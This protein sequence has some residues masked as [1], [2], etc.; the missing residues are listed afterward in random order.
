MADGNASSSSETID[1]TAPVVMTTR[2][3]KY[4]ARPP[5]ANAALVREQLLLAHRYRNVLVEIERARRAVT[6]DLVAAAPDVIAA[7][8]VARPLFA[9]MLAA[10]GTI[11]AARSAVR[12]RAIDP[13]LVDAAKAARVAY[14]DALRVLGKARNAA[15]KAA[16][17]D[18]TLDVFHEN[19]K[20]LVKSAREQCGAFW[21][22][23]LLCEDA[24]NRSKSDVPLWDELEPMDPDFRRWSGEG[25]VGVQLQGGLSAEEVFAYDPRLR[26]TPVDPREFDKAGRIAR[27]LEGA[28]TRA[29]RTTLFLRVGSQG[30]GNRIP[31]WA[32]FP[33]V[34]HRPLPPGAVIKRA[35]VSVRKI[36]PHEKWTTEITITMPKP[37]PAKPVSEDGV[38]RVVAVDL[39]WRV[40]GAEVRVGT[41]CD[42]EGRT[43]IRFDARLMSRLRK[44]E[45]LASIRE[46]NFNLAQ[47]ALVRWLAEAPIALPTWLTDATRSLSQWHASSRLASLAVAWRTQRFDGDS[48]GFEALE[49]WR[50]QDKHLWTWEAAQR[51]NTLLARRE[52]F[53]VA[54]AKLAEDHD[55]LVLEDLNLS[56]LARRAHVEQVEGDNGNARS[57]RQ[58]VSPSELRMALE[59]AFVS[60]GKQIHYASCAYTTRTCNGC[61]SVETWDQAADVSHTCAVCG[62]RW[63]QDDNAA[64]NLLALYATRP[65][66]G[67][68]GKTVKK[69]R[70]AQP[71]DV[72]GET[73]WER[74]RRVATERAGRMEAQR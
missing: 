24:I 18:G 3:Y 72:E 44:V 2:V 12:A 54:A 13:A 15:L 62:D 9:A 70:K 25:T 67:V 43:E 65:E 74:V 7:D 32:E 10:Y 33:I 49:A 52:V 19:E 35:N 42:S 30:P 23:Y 22:T 66:P 39:G 26:I 68:R 14:W 63:D 45:D 27:R 16:R 73:R 69:K 48:S 64:R 71:T 40:M 6:R 29:G 56:K 55:V 11:K 41:L 50:K 21:G 8:A 5:T 46:K 31:V 53:R 59:Q 58:A 34:M 28:T 47:A 36:G 20:L 38:Q 60:R 1:L 17:D 57:N 4:G 51:Q 61:G 37:V